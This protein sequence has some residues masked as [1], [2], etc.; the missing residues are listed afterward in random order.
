MPGSRSHAH[1]IIS[2]ECS[3]D[4]L[5]RAPDPRHRAILMRLC[6]AC[7]PLLSGLAMVSGRTLV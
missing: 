7:C 6:A 1:G 3:Q 4:G 5:G 2:S